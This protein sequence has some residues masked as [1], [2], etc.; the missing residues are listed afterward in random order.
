[1]RAV[2]KHQVGA[3]FHRCTCK[4]HHIPPIFA[5]IHLFGVV[6][7]QRIGSF[8]A[9]MESNNDKVRGLTSAADKSGDEI[10]IMD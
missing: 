10:Q 6:D 4:L 9:A 5:K 3:R 8:C 1:M 7:P 2:A